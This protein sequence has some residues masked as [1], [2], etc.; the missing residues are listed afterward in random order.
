MKTAVAV[1][2]SALTVTA[3]A[4]DL[5]LG[6]G[7]PLAGTKMKNVDGK[8]IAIADVAGKKGTLVIFTCNHCPFVKAW[9]E[10]MAALGNTYH[11]QGIGTIMLN[12]NDPAVAGDTFEGMQERAKARGFNFPY[13]VDAGSTVAKAFG[14]TRT[15]EIFLFDNAGKLVYHG[16]V[17]DNKDAGNVKQSYLKDAIEALLAGKEIATKTTKAIGCSIKFYK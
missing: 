6:D 15:P 10:R 16:A 4:A 3:F 9:E 13:V 2:L 7:I 17:D 5:K 11:S 12:P 8:S 1:L 14:A